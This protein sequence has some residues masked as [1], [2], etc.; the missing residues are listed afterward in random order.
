MDFHYLIVKNLTVI[1]FMIK[2]F[3][4]ESL[5]SGIELNHI[6]LDDK[7]LNPLSVMCLDCNVSFIVKFGSQI[8]ATQGTTT[9]GQ[10]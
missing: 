1:T 8:A 3:D 2:V 10:S 5:I 9:K 6:R 4:L 7:N